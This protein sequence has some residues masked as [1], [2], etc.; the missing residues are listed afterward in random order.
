MCVSLLSLLY[1]IFKENL[2]QGYKG[3]GRNL[4][5][6]TLTLE[7]RMMC[8]NA[9]PTYALP[10]ALGRCRSRSYPLGHYF[11]LLE[12]EKVAS[13]ESGNKIGLTKVV[14]RFLPVERKGQHAKK[15]LLSI[16]NNNKKKQA[17]MS[18]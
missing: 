16:Q 3:G 5:P 8:E 15:P 17:P 18:M 10:T 4:K 13:E 6:P 2:L 11:K 12:R 7:V 1:S 9:S 14:D